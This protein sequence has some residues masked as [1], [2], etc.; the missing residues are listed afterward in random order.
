MKT[1]IHY[2]PVC[3][4]A[5][6]SSLTACNNNTSKNASS[7][8]G[9][10]ASDTNAALKK[11]EEEYQKDLENYKKEK[12]EAIAANEKTIAA[13]KSKIKLEKKEMH[14]EYEKKI[15]VLE[16]KNQAIKVKLSEY[17]SEG[18]DKWESFKREFNHDMEELGNAL[19]EFATDNEK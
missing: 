19:K 7:D 1:R 6:F 5:L 12:E 15:A 9:I 4:I 14:L 8:S 11:E 16:Q 2:I 10:Q 3:C 13:L 18:K 17:K